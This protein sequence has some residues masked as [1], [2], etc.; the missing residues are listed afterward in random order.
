MD[1]IVY[2]KQC[3]LGILIPIALKQ[4]ADE[5]VSSL[6]SQD[7]V[8]ADAAVQEERE[9]NSTMKDPSSSTLYRIPCGKVIR[10]DDNV[11][12]RILLGARIS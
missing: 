1:D 6:A 11:L 9:V 7:E 8:R 4:N 10:V 2:E 12:C 3:F 5:V